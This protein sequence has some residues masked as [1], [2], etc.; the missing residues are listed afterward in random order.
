MSEGAGEKPSSTILY[1]ALAAMVLFWSLNYIAGKVALRDF[2]AALLAALRVTFAAAMAM[3]LYWWRNRAKGPRPVEGRA[4]RWRIV[5][6]LGVTGVALNQ[7][8]FVMG[9][10]RTS[11]AHTSILIAMAP[12]MVLLIAAARGMERLTPGKIAGMLIAIAG[13]GVLNAGRAPGTHATLAGDLLVLAG[14][15]CFAVFTVVGKIATRWYDSLT[16]TAMAYATGAAILAPL[17]V[18]QSLS[19]DYSRVSWMGWASVLFMAAFP[20]VVCYLIF[21]WAMSHIPA[22]RVSSF[23]YLQPPIATL[24]AVPVLG[25]RVTWPLLF[26]G[27]LAIGGVFLTERAR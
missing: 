12:V 4:P 24:L 27:A 13:V 21:Y 22:S 16:V 14:S 23:S 26:G 5:L 25:E 1:G 15:F 11:V 20:S 10:S 7:L 17:T 3:P 9:L 18:R 2:P 6:L 8:F 19:F